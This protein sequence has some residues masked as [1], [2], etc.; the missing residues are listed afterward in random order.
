MAIK[1]TIPTSLK[2]ITLRQ[3]KKFLNISDNLKTSDRFVNAKL[4]EIFCKLPLTEVMRLKVRDSEE[5][6]ESI[7]KMFEEK[8]DLVKQ[9]KIGK[10]E[11]GFHP[12]LDDMSLGEYIDL[13]T[14]IGDWDNI[15]K[16]MAVLYRPVIT[17]LKGKYIIQDYEVGKG[18]TVLDMPMDC[19]MSSIFFLW[20]L[21]LEL[22]QTMTN[23]LEQ[24]E[25]QALTQSLNFQANGGGINRFTDSLTEMLKGLKVSLN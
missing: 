10:T 19:V 5:I 18:E 4:I 6:T 2:D 16:A 25:L 11:Y 9:F 23:S 12:K 3:Y 17:E 13:D 21:G 8:P 24:E 7:Y 1:I 20:N 14:F 22:S 15:E